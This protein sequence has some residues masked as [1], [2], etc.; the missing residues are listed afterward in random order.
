MLKEKNKEKLRDRVRK[1]EGQ[2]QETE[3]QVSLNSEKGDLEKEMK[4]K[5]LLP[6]PS[7]T[8]DERPLTFVSGSNFLCFLQI[9]L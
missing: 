4:L 9:S 8:A 2:R 6:L 3:W 5:V 7:L 1:K